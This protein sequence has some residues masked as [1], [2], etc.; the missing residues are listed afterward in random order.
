[1]AR[2]ELREQRGEQLGLRAQDDVDACLRDP[3][4][5]E[6]AE[7]ARDPL[8]ALSVARIGLAE[9]L[10]HARLGH[11]ERALEERDRD[12]RA[13]AAGRAVDPHGALRVLGDRSEQRTDRSSSIEEEVSVVALD[14]R[15]ELQLSIAAHEEAREVA[16]ADVVARIL[17]ER[18]V[19]PMRDDEPVH[20]AT[21]ALALGAEVTD[22]AD[23]ERRDPRV[24]VRV[25]ARGHL[26]AEEPPCAHA[27]S[28][29]G[30]HVAGVA[31][32]RERTHA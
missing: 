30:R 13:V 6:R 4:Q 25:Q 32:I 19:H 17:V 1:V 27:R 3:P 28:A 24:I 5:R 22:E 21:R 9:A 11:A 14:E 29:R 16:Q 26:G 31:E 2:L 20:R 12:A 7:H 15:V 23:A 8:E 10:E 18:V